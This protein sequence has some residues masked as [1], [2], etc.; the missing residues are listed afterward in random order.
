MKRISLSTT[1]H[2]VQLIK[3][4]LF[5]YS[6]SELVLEMSPTIFSMYKTRQLFLICWSGIWRT[7]EVLVRW[8]ETLTSQSINGERRQ[9]VVKSKRF[10]ILVLI[11]PTIYAFLLQKNYRSKLLAQKSCAKQFC[12]KKQLT[13]C[14]W[15]WRHVETAFQHPSLRRRHKNGFQE[16]VL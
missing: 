10:S 13:K 16:S 11:S 4:E 14:W 1:W 12:T 7:F 15:N 8:E 5:L 3:N 6:E 2:E 9:M